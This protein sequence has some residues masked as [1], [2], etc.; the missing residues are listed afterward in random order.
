MIC[1]TTAAKYPVRRRNRQTSADLVRPHGTGDSSIRPWCFLDPSGAR[2]AYERRPCNSWGALASWR[3]SGRIHA[4]RQDCYAAEYLGRTSVQS[5]WRVAKVVTLMSCACL[6]LSEDQIWKGGASSRRTPSPC[7]ASE[8]DMLG[9]AR[10]HPCPPPGL[11]TPSVRC[12]TT[13]PDLPPQAR[14]PNIDTHALITSGYRASGG[15]S[16]GSPRSRSKFGARSL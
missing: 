8:D 3:Y 13:L 10:R 7:V 4:G 9:V 5:A 15:R 1:E 2:C 11:K 6:S 16:R 14:T 12:A